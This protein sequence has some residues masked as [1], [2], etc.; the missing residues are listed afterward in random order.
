MPPKRSKSS[1]S[2][3]EAISIATASL[4]AHKMRTVLTL[5]GVVIGVTAVIAVVSLVGG[6][7]TY[8]ARM[9]SNN[10]GADTFI[11]D[12]SPSVISN[13]DQ[14]QEAQKRRKFRYD[15]YNYLLDNCRSCRAV[16]ASLSTQGSVKYGTQSLD[17]ANI[18][19]FTY[20]MPEVY[21]R[22]LMMGRYFTRLDELRHAPVCDVGYDVFDKL[23]PGGNPIGKEIRVDSGECEIIGVADKRG[24]V[25]GQSQ[26]DWVI[27]PLTTYQTIYG[28]NDS[29]TLWV[30]ATSTK[31]LDTTMDE[32]RLLLRGRRHVPYLKADDFAM[33]TNESFLQL[34]N[35]ISSTFFGVTIGIASISLIVGGIVIMNIMLVSVTERTR[36]IGLRK[37]LGARRIDIQKQ[38]LIESSTISAIGGAIGV[39]LGILAAKIVTWTTALPSSVALWSVLMGLLVAIGVGLFFGVY[40][41]TKAA[42]LDPVVAL[43]SE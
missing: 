38:F 32:V 28:G 7:N 25:M 24:S 21:K 36:E 2:L 42:R 43:R 16:A 10:L 19:G 3:S 40:P 8:V 39:S 22:D 29:L 4:W 15:D 12:R 31:T 11:V 41:A 34:W 6:L 27:M 35:S 26:D 30:K 33:E 18:I 9:I 23:M 1:M 5:L 37:S 17:T 13:I 14:W 20:Q